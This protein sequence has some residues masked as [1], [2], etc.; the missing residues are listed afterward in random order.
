[1]GEEHREE[2]CEPGPEEACGPDHSTGS[3]DG[4]VAAANGQ[5]PSP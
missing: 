4:A 2:G 5:S 3:D 1:V